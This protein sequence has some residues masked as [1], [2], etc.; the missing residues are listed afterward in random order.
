MRKGQ[1]APF[2]LIISIVMST[3]KSIWRDPRIERFAL[4]NL[5]PMDTH[6]DLRWKTRDLPNI[7]LN[8][9]WYP[10]L[11]YK[12]T[13]DWWNQKYLKW[14]PKTY[15]DI[16]PIVNNDGMIWAIKMGS[17][18]YFCAKH[19]CYKF[20][21]GIMFDNSDDCVKLGVWFRECDPLNNQDHIPYQGTF[22]YHDA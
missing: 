18:R 17:N 14:R 4:A 6:S 1:F 13:P 8:G 9:L 22:S 19:L 11:I 15:Y 20:I 5:T 16:K 21:D 7:S 3:L 10:I 12:V 2:L